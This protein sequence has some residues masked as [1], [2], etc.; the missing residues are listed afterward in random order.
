MARALADAF[1][2]DPVMSWLVPDP[3]RRLHALADFFDFELEHVALRH[4]DSLVARADATIGGVA[5]VL[6]PGHWRTPFSLQLHDGLRLGNV[7]RHRLGHA[8]ALQAALE[9]RHLSEPHYY[10]P[11]IGVA[12]AHRGQGVGSLL[13]AELAGRCDREQLP[14]YLEAT[15]PANVRLYRRHGFTTLTTL[16]AWGSPP[17]ELMVRRPQDGDRSGRDVDV[18]RRGGAAGG[19]VDAAEDLP[20]VGVGGEDAGDG[21]DQGLLAAQELTGA[22]DELVGDRA[23]LGGRVPVERLRWQLVADHPLG[24]RDVVLELAQRELPAVDGGVVGG[25]RA[26]PAASIAAWRQVSQSCRARITA[27]LAAPTEASTFAWIRRRC[28]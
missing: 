28:R 27:S 3:R 22:E 12:G 24:H 21:V 18:D 9:R 2:G 7:F 16:T 17:L 4:P 1:V 19:V 6:P 20:A 8:I 13:L 14:A 11:F 15:S 26:P 5:V 23:E 25:H 10:L